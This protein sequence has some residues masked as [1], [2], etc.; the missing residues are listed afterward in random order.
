M[1][2]TYF[3]RQGFRM[4]VGNPM[5]RRNDLNPNSAEATATTFRCFT[6]ADPGAIG[7][8]GTPPADTFH[9]PKGVCT[10][11]I[12]SNIYFPQCVYVSSYLLETFHRR[13]SMRYSLDAGMESPSIHQTTK[14]MSRTPSELDSSGMIVPPA[15]PFGFHSYSWRS[16][17]T[18]GRSITE[19]GGLRMWNSLSSSAWVIRTSRLRYTFP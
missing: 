6:G 11:G 15:I 10:G 2:P 18:L 7:A 17:G 9:L 12:R 8:P 5:R 16:S 3:F 14:A 19:I 4:I 13:S 1:S